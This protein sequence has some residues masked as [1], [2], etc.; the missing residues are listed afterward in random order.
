M[1]YYHGSS[2]WSFS[3]GEVGGARRLAGLLVVVETDKCGYL[4]KGL[5]YPTLYSFSCANSR[6]ALTV[7]DSRYIGQSLGTF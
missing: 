5:G 3:K 2:L 6:V 4:N 7:F 1:N